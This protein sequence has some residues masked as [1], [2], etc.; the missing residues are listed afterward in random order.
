MAGEFKRNREELEGKTNT[1]NRAQGRADRWTEY[2]WWKVAKI[3]VWNKR[4]E[5]KRGREKQ[6]RA[7]GRREWS[8][9]KSLEDE[10]YQNSGTPGRE[11]RK[12][13]Q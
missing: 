8:L 4:E 13:K 3:S 6:M 5:R 9:L 7:S 11:E 12:R 2:Q 10:A 1:V